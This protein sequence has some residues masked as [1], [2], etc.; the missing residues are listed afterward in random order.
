MI[1]DVKL[2]EKLD[3]LGY[4]E[5]HKGTGYIRAAVAAVDADPE[6]YKLTAVYAEVARRASTTPACVERCIRAATEAAF[7]AAGW[8]PGAQVFGNCIATRTKPN[9]AEVIARLRRLCHE[10]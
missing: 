1:N 5:S 8:E 3:F 7:N 6:G 2:D 4:S 10:D 9:N